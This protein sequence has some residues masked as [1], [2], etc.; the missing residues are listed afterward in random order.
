MLE[1]KTITI[2]GEELMIQQ[3]GGSLALKHSIILGRLFGGMSKGVESSGV[4]NIQDW[5]IDFGKMVDGIIS[6]LDPESSPIWIK[7]LVS[8]SVI[9]PEYSITWFDTTFSGNL[10]ELLKLVEKILEHNYGGLMEYARKKMEAIF[11]SE[12]SSEE[13]VDQKQ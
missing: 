11:T 7:E 10:E 6:S 2:A 5:N 3:L 9:K 4:A 12:E 13:M 8:Q 1:Q